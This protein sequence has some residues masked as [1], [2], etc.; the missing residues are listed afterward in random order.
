MNRILA[1]A[2]ALAL[3]FAYAATANAACNSISI[4]ASITVLGIYQEN[5]TDYSDAGKDAR[6]SLNVFTDIYLDNDYSENVSTRLKMTLQNP[7]DEWGTEDVVMDW[8][9]IEFKEFL[10]EGLTF[11]IG[12]LTWNWELRPVWGAGTFENIH[13]GNVNHAFVLKTTGPGMLFTYQFTDEIKVCFG[14]MKLVENSV[15]GGSNANDVDLY[16]VRY[17]QKIGEVNKFFAAFIYYN[18]QTNNAAGFAG[19]IWQLDAGIDYF[20]ME[21]NLELY[22]ELAYQA[23]NAHVAGV[24]LGAMAIDAGVEYTFKDVNTIPYLGLDITY[25][26]GVDGATNAYTF[27]TS[28]WTQTLIAENQFFG[29]LAGA[30]Q[31]WMGIKLLGGMKSINNDKFAIDF[32]LGLF[33]ANGDLVPAGRGDGLGFEIDVVASYMYSED[34]TFSIGLGYFNPDE[35]LSGAIG[36]ADPDG[37]WVAL[38]ACTI[39]F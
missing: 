26:Q 5:D 31:G 19:N 11:D 23:G 13:P 20:V 16:V 27:Y 39:V 14:F 24:D 30:T 4:G 33:S 9:Y 38:F 3:V 10:A 35:D 21:E 18:D 22:I 29:G 7:L 15:V 28:S 36:V 2:G 1:F 8:V 12:Q 17:D 25:V 32:V 6:S 34:V 37:V